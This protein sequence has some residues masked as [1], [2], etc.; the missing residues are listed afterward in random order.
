MLLSEIT[1]NN[2]SY[3]I[4]GNIELEEFL[5]IMEEIYVENA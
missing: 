3:I 2:M 4:Y 5:K 1:Y